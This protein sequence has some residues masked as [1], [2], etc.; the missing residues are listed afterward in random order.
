[1]TGTEGL[2]GQQINLL[3]LQLLQEKNQVSEHSPWFSHNFPCNS[4]T[5]SLGQDS[6]IDPDAVALLEDLLPHDSTDQHT[7]TLH[8]VLKRQVCKL[9]MHNSSTCGS[10]GQKQ[11][12]AGCLVIPRG[13]AT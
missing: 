9:V 3:Q 5:R 1:M 12:V 4:T 13:P 8:F 11:C 7:A 2:D 6:A 10:L